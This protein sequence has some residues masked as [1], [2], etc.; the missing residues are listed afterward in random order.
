M[1]MYVHTTGKALLKC[2]CCR[3][4]GLKS[5]YWSAF[6][7]LSRY[8]FSTDFN[9]QKFKH[10]FASSVLWFTYLKYLIVKK[11]RKSKKP[12]SVSFPVNSQPRNGDT[13]QR[14]EQCVLTGWTLGAFSSQH[15]PY[16]HTNKHEQARLWPI[17]IPLHLSLYTL[18]RA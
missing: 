12:S 7:N 10:S 17:Y 15:T 4:E 13:K 2:R 18:Y 5:V 16:K 9:S 6:C 1:G 14:G 8:S 3:L 11:A